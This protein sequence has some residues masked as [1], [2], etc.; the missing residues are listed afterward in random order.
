M[1]PVLH[2]NDILHAFFNGDDPTGTVDATY[3]GVLQKYVSNFVMVGN[4]NG[5]GLLAWPVEGG[6][7]TVMD[8]TSD[9]PNVQRDT[10]EGEKCAWLRQ[11]ELLS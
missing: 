7:F 5:V 6:N 8:M 3:A 11:N 4:P 10:T 9:G 2:N 1:L